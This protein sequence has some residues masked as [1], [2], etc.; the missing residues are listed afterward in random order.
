PG[1]PV[2]L[3][4]LRNGKPMDVR[5]VLGERPQNAG[6]TPGKGEAPSGSALEGVSVQ[7]LTPGIRDQLGIPANATGVVVADVS[8]DSPAAEYLQQGDVIESINRQPVHN[9][10]DFNRLAGEAKGQVL[11]RVIH[12]GQGFF[13]VISPGPP[14]DGGG[15]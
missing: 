6:V 9:V 4:I 13:V 14:G 12:Q 2:T 3:S 8:Q 10:N 1:A 7:N 15:Q 11:L 5:V